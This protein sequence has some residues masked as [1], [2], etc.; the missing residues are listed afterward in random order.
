MRQS[1]E[2]DLDRQ[3]A[4]MCMRGGLDRQ[5]MY[6]ARESGKERERAQHGVQWWVCE[7][8]T[9]VNRVEKGVV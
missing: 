3:R 8:D 4:C 5:C 9:F 6:L 2:S 1:L 7:R